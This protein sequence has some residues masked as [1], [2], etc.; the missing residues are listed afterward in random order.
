[1]FFLT[2]VVAWI[3]APMHRSSFTVS[4]VPYSAACMS[5]VYPCWEKKEKTKRKDEDREKKGDE[6][7]DEDRYEEGKKEKE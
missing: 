5:G 1:M 4:I 3:S 2:A 6:N 7:E